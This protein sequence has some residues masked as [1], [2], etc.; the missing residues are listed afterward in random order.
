MLKTVILNAVSCL[1][2]ATSHVAGQSLLAN[3]DAEI[4]A[5]VEKI[6]PSVVTVSAIIPNKKP[7]DSFFSFLKESVPGPAR[8]EADFTTNIGT[9]FV[10]HEQGFVATKSSVVA[11]AQ[12]IYVQF[13]EDTTYMAELMGID[14]EFSVAL[15]RFDTK[16][17]KSLDFGDPQLLRAGSWTVLVGNSLG[18]SSTVSL[19]NIN[20]VYANGLLQIA[21]NTSPGNNG[22]PVMNSRGQIIGMVSGRLTISGGTNRG[23][24]AATECALVTPIDQVLQASGR[25]MAEY[26]KNHGWLG[27][28]VRPFERNLPQIVALL[29]NSPAALSGLAIGDVVT[30][31]N[32]NILNGYYDL[33][34]I[35]A[36]VKPGHAVEVQVQRRG[37][38]RKFKFRAAHLPD[39]PHFA[40]I[41]PEIVKAQEQPIFKFGS[42]NTRSRDQI[43]RR[44]L[45]MEQKLQFLQNQIQ[46][47]Q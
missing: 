2:I 11:G 12:H 25:I 27:I 21:V 3:L 37:Q 39:V 38:T 1:T 6:Q 30:K 10:L 22:S 40:Q 24:M 7:D 15:L 20:A 17:L 28:T 9:G 13:D 35:M 8:P 5:I 42:K 19:G 23:S 4:N 26:Q 46:K 41:N 31:I 32:A 36:S 16:N 18:I 33:K 47:K 29:E 45:L 14:S 43:E 34:R 44:L